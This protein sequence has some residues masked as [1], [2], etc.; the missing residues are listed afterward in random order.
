MSRGKEKRIRAFTLIELLVVIAIIGI[1]AA[2]L[3]PTL[4]IAKKKGS[5]AYCINNLKQLSLGMKMYVDDN[6][7]DFPGMASLHNGFQPTD[8]IYWRTNTIYPPLMKSP[9]VSAV[10]GGNPSLFRCPL[11]RN[12]ADRL[13]NPLSGTDGPYLYSYSFTGYGSTDGSGVTGPGLASTVNNGMSSFYHGDPDSPTAVPFKYANV[14]N[15]SGKIM[16]AEEPGENVP[17]D[18]PS[19]GDIITDGRW[20]PGAFPG[21]CD[22]LTVRHGGRA[23]AAFADGHVEAVTWQFATNIANSMP[24][25]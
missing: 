14:R 11:D 20:M 22:F 18:T 3:L 6:N 7:D 12:D 19:P 13:A 8:W 15:P 5:Q 4:S 24:N 9:I 2:L 17:G 10:P 21:V 23:D 25:L 1:L 16:L